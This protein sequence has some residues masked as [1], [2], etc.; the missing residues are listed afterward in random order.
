MNWLGRPAR[1]LFFSALCLTA[2][3][4]CAGRACEEKPV[5]PEAAANAFDGAASLSKILTES[6]QKVVI[7]ARRGQDLEKYGVTFSHAAFAV[8]DD[9]WQ[10]FH[11]LNVCGSAI[12]KLYAQGLAE[13]LGDDL[14]SQ[15]VAVVV[16]E[17]WLQD[18]L[19][20]VLTTKEEQSRMH[21]QAYSAVAYPYD[22]KYQNSNGWLL[23]TYARAASEVKL[24]GRA[25]AQAWL[26]IAG[27]APSVIELGPLT[28]LGVRMFK[29][30]VS[31]DDQPSELRWA[32]K[33]TTSTGDSVLRLVS[34][35][36]VKQPT[37][38]HGKFADT[39][40]VVTP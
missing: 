36:A 5:Q 12:S 18:R 38:A 24:R 39:V 8:N 29:A 9:G 25:E 11:D 27:Y 26:K 23:E 22:I 33:I 31:F 7:L 3:A 20:Q 19:L 34:R 16:P 1:S 40:C 37:C 14:M 4:A 30:N 28:R 10:V 13:F 32:N 35:G 17:P 6:G 2:G 21:E 15:E